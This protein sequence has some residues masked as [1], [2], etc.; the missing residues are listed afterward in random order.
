M[1]LYV[2][3]AVYSTLCSPQLS[4]VVFVPNVDVTFNW[5][6]SDS[7]NSGSDHDT[8]TRS[9]LAASNVWF[10][11]QNSRVGEIVSE[12]YVRGR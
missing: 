8:F 7:E 3:L 10:T 5:K 11:G 4:D 9:P 1:S 2:F 6:P 12:M